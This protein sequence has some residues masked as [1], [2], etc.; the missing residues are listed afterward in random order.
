MWSISPILS[1]MTRGKS[2]LH[3]FRC[4][5]IFPRENHCLKSPKG[6]VFQNFDEK[7]GSSP[8]GTK[9]IDQGSE[10]RT[11]YCRCFRWSRFWRFQTKTTSIFCESAYVFRILH[12]KREHSFMFERRDGL[13]PAWTWH[14]SEYAS[15]C[16]EKAVFTFARNAGAKNRFLI[17]NRFVYP[18][19]VEDFQ[20]EGFLWGHI[21]SSDRE[22]K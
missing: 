2:P 8:E 10:R 3:A 11:L 6:T 19:P 14:R 22:R 7:I 15:L 18:N 9:L 16:I 1:Y 21:K 4:R 5:L 20:I 13:F 12:P 17:T